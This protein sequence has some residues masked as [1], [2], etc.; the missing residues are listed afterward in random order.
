VGRLEHLALRH[1][2]APEALTVGAVRLVTLALTPIAEA[3]FH[4]GYSRA[5]PI[6]LLTNR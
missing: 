5:R 1:W 4:A 2:L 6:V 3:L